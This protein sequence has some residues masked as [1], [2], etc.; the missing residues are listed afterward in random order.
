MCMLVR[1]IRGTRCCYATA[2][3]LVKRNMKYI[4]TRVAD[5]SEPVLSVALKITKR[6]S[7][8][9][10][11][12]PRVATAAAVVHLRSQAVHVAEAGGVAVVVGDDD[13]RVER[14]EVQHNHRVAVEA[15]L[16]LHHQ[17][18]ALRRPL[19]GP[20]LDAGRHG[21]VV[22][23][24]GHAEHHGLDAVLLAG[25][26]KPIFSNAILLGIVI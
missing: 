16:R 24:L 2:V 13:G 15:R 9:G 23:R 11:T 4:L 14:L 25:A 26:E 17:R 22:Q 21:D 3:I 10:E 19:L 6:R 7:S 8:G 1:S 5:S 18:K 20:L 12:T